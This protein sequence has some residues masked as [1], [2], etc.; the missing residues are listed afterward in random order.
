M[1]AKSVASCQ[2]TR[3]SSDQS[4]LSLANNIQRSTRNIDKFL[5]GLGNF[6]GEELLP[7]PKSNLSTSSSFTAPVTYNTSHR[8][9]LS[10]SNLSLT[11]SPSMTSVNSTAASS[12][13]TSNLSSSSFSHTKSSSIGNGSDVFVVEKILWEVF[14]SC[15]TREE[16][17]SWKPEETRPAIAAALATFFRHQGIPLSNRQNQLTLDSIPSFVWRDKKAL[18]SK[19]KLHVTVNSHYF[20]PHLCSVMTVVECSLCSNV[21]WGAGYQGHRCQ[22]CDMV[23]HNS[24]MRLPSVP[25]CSKVPSKLRSGREEHSSTFYA[26]GPCQLF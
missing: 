12:R 26:P 14:E 19:L 9:P 24:C 1:H 23:F 11:S 16:E 4:Q 3:M 6:F 17:N 18:K 8:P 21:L 2:Q 10:H 20:V 13:G 22:C 5:P 15:L 25:Q 7:K